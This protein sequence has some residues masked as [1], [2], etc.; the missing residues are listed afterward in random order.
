MIVELYR[1]LTTITRERSTAQWMQV[2]QQLDIPATPIYGLDELVEHPHLRAVGL[3]QDAVHPTEGPMRYVAPPTRFGDSP[4]R[5]RFQAPLLG[6][7]TSEILRE[8]G[9][10]EADIAALKQRGVVAEKS[11]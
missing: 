8:A 5:V 6:Q 1:D 3:F 11:A 7:H 4:A 2:C 10:A 9:Y